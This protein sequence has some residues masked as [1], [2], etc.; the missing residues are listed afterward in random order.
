MVWG[1]LICKISAK[2]F[3]DKFIQLLVNLRVNFSWSSGSDLSFLP[4]SMSFAINFLLFCHTIKIIIFLLLCTAHPFFYLLLIFFIFLFSFWFSFI[5]NL[6]KFMSKPVNFLPFALLQFFIIISYHPHLFT[7]SHSQPPT[8][9]LPPPSAGWSKPLIYHFVYT[10]M[11]NG[12]W[13][14]VFRV[15]FSILTYCT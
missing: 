10:N 4:N 15:F 12:L 7:L 8:S 3:Q 9:P 11:E 14:I 2:I 5:V 6:C 13:F 1:L